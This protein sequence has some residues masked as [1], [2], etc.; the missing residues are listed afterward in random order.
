MTYKERYEK[1]ADDFLKKMIG[2]H[3]YNAFS[4]TSCQERCVYWLLLIALL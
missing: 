2:E 4:N 1:I 3:P